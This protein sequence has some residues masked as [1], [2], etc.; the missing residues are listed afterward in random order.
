MSLRAYIEK[1]ALQFIAV[2]KFFKGLLL[3][4]AGIGARHLAHRDIVLEVE[5]WADA[6]RIDPSNRYIHLLLMHLSNLDEKKLR[7]LSIGTFLYAAVFLTEGTGLW[8][9][10]RWAEYFTILVTSSFIPLEVYEI[11]R[12]FTAPRLTLLLLNLAI[13]AYLVFDLRSRRERGDLLQ[14]AAPSIGSGSI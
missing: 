12:R 1:H 3:L 11:Y 2:F 5:R 10:K 7:E 8:F 6:F 14:Q 13:V 4:V 9:E